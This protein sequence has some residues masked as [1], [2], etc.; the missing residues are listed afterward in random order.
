MT[1]TDSKKKM[2]RKCVKWGRA[3]NGKRER[4]RQKRALKSTVK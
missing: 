2:L 4:K 1:K 3:M